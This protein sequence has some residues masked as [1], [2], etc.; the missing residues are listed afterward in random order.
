MARR[1]G[2]MTA[3][4]FLLPYALSRSFQGGRAATQW[5]AELSG[6]SLAAYGSLELICACDKG[7]GAGCPLV[8]R[9][10]DAYELCLGI[11]LFIADAF[12]PLA[13]ERRRAQAGLR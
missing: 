11:V 12:S 8:R 7:E 13:I 2:M 4:G 5:R 1:T 3:V 6:I 10:K 9:P